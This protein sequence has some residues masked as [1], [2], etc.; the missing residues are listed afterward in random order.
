MAARQIDGNAMRG[1]AGISAVALL[2]AFALDVSIVVP[3]VF[4]AL[5]IGAI[6][7]LKASPLGAA[8]RALK[9]GLRLRIPVKPEDEPPPRFAQTLGAV[10]LGAA[11]AAFIADASTLGWVLALLVAA[12]QTLLAVTGICVGCEMYL[13]GK[14]LKA[15]AAA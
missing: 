13:L 7:G 15:K 11:T 2:I 12:L 1:G 14:R 5:A 6:F 3:F 10:V 9:S 8:F 4:V